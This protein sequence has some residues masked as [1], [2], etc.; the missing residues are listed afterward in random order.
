MAPAPVQCGN[1]RRRRQRRRYGNVGK[2]VVAYGV[3]RLH[4]ICL[5]TAGAIGE[6]SG[7]W[8][9][10]NTE[11]T[12]CGHPSRRILIDIPSARR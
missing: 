11:A 1:V 3:I 9:K 7:E 12:S 4:H 6:T 5:H 8:Q 2:T 10:V